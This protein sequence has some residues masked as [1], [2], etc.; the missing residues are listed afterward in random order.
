LGYIIA[1]HFG[2]QTQYL[3]L[4]DDIDVALFFTCC[5]HIKNNIY[6]PITSDDLDEYGKY[7]IRT[8]TQSVLGETYISL[9]TIS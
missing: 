9:F 8:K 2:L 5:K 7:T 4:T 3:D 6:K 1:Q